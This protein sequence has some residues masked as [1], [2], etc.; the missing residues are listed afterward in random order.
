MELS[1]G[2]ISASEGW[3]NGDYAIGWQLPLSDEFLV[4]SKAVTVRSSTIWITCSLHR[5]LMEKQRREGF[6]ES[7]EKETG[8]LAATGFDVRDFCANW[9]GILA[10]S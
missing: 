2:K 9:S 4:S 3:A 8:C 5:I 10:V 1:E 7:S 6:A